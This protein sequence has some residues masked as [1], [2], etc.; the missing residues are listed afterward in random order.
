MTHVGNYRIGVGKCLL[1]DVRADEAIVL[2]DNLRAS[3]TIVTA[4]SL[5]VE[6][7]IPVTDNK[8]AF[9]L[10]KNGAVIAGE[11]DGVKIDGYDIGN[12]PIELQDIFQKSPFKKLVLKT[13]NMIPLLVCLPGALICSSLNFESIVRYLKENDV[14]IIAVGGKNGA[15]EDLGVAFALGASLSGALFDKNLI[16]C[17]TQES[18]AAKHLKAIG[19]HKDIDFISRNSV[20][21][22]VPWYDGNKIVNVVREKKEND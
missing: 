17:F 5:G 14:Y 12:S 2:I 16:T 8:R 18:S 1:H 13:S 9:K 10:K 3:S 4:L 7:I 11:S 22:V 20:F 21:D 19:Y 6:E 15:A